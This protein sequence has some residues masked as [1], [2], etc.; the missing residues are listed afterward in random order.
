MTRTPR[1]KTARSDLYLR[2]I[3]AASR[4]E[5]MGFDVSLVNIA[6]QIGMKPES[7]GRSH[8]WKTAAID[9]DVMP[10]QTPARVVR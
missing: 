2:I 3:A 7:L 8:E 10:E 1:S 9:G 4:L 6:R 5:S